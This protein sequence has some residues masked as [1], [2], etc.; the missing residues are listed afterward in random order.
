M[1]IIFCYFYKIYDRWITACSVTIFD[2]SFTKLYSICKCF[3]YSSACGI[4]HQVLVSKSFQCFYCVIDFIHISS[5]DTKNNTCF[6]SNCIH[7]SVVGWCSTI[8]NWFAVFTYSQSSFC[9]FYI[10]TSQYQSSA[11]CSS[12]LYK[13]YIIIRTFCRVIYINQFC[14]HSLTDTVI[15][16]LRNFCKF[17]FNG[18]FIHAVAKR[19]CISCFVNECF[20]MTFHNGFSTENHFFCASTDFDAL[21][22]R[23]CSFR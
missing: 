7:L 22:W 9:Y 14:I 18:S 20:F 8:Q 16:N 19:I 1:Q 2:C 21:H 17:C 23:C 5:A 3:F 12:F 11:K 10:C 13:F 15:I 6:C 4:N